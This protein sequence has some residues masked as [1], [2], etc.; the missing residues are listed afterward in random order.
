MRYPPGAFCW[1]G[2]AASDPD[3]AKTFYQGLFGWRPEER[4]AA[5]IGEFTTMRLGSKA[6]ALVYRQTA[7]ARAA[8]VPPHWTSFVSV[9]VADRA[10]ARA[11]ELGGTVVR[12]SFEVGE[13]GRVATV[14]DPT[15]A[16]VSLWE[17]R[18]EA[19]AD[20]RDV[21]GGLAWNEL[22]TPDPERAAAFYGE[23][24]GWRCVGRERFY[25]VQHAGAVI[26]I[27]RTQHADERG[28]PP[29][30]L[31]CFA[32]DDLEAAERRAIALGGRALGVAAAAPGTF[33]GRTVRLAD[34]LGADFAAWEPH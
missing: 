34:P 14:R 21:V 30:W 17:P 3:V 33:G 25:A 26:A 32:V 11:A 1:V 15:G 27:I 29:N 20:L 8:R 9:K 23:L 28:Q 12:D 10:E 5:G 18:R 6:V 16:I 7:E 19:G 4:V 22:S 31:P 2:L 24:L 13:L